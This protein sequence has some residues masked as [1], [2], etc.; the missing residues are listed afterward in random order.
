MPSKRQPRPH[1]VRSA[2]LAVAAVALLP[3]SAP[4]STRQANFDV[5]VGP[6]VGTGTVNCPAGERATGGGYT[7][8]VT[9]GN[10][11]VIGASRKLGQSTWTATVGSYDGG[12]SIATVYVYCSG[13]GPQTTQVSKTAPISGSAETLVDA[14]CDGLGTIQ[15][16]GFSTPARKGV[17]V[18]SIRFGNRWRVRAQHFAGT[19]PTV[20][21]YAYCA[22]ASA[23]VVREGAPVS[24][25]GSEFKTAKS[26]P[27]AG[28]AAPLAGGFRQPPWATAGGGFDTPNELRRLNGRWRA[29]ARH[30]QQ[31][32]S[33]VATAYCP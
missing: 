4:A 1:P 8:D 15:A 30:Q 25:T 13:Q 18:T 11:R 32:S 17:V 31:T 7:A 24:G 14:R 22:K 3:T 12:G 28:G 5:P 29:R 10:A 9:G 26:A 20:T 6:A 27:C 19:T 16:G 33:F 2:V 21:S 23:P